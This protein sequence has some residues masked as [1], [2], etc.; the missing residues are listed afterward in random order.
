MSKE[1][2]E[3]SEAQASL[4]EAKEGVKNV[5]RAVADAARHNWVGVAV[6]VVKN[7]RSFLIG[8][9]ILLM[10]PFVLFVAIPAAL[11]GDSVEDPQL[12]WEEDY[13]EVV[14]KTTEGL[15]KGYNSYVKEAKRKGEAIKNGYGAGNTI[16]VV[17]RPDMSTYELSSKMANRMMATY[18]VIQYNKDS[19]VDDLELDSFDEYKKSYYTAVGKAAVKSGSRNNLFTIDHI[20]QNVYEVTETDEDGETHSYYRGTIVV[21]VKFRP[22]MFMRKELDQVIKD[23]GGIVDEFISFN[24]EDATPTQQ[25]IVQATADTAWPG[26]GLCATWAS[27]VYSNAG[28]GGYGGNANDMWANY[29]Y[30]DDRSELAPGMFIAVEH[31]G[32]DYESWTYGHVG[33]YIGNDQV[34]HS[35]SSGVVVNTVDEWIAIFDPYN[36]VRWGYP[37]AVREQIEEEAG[38]T[39]DYRVISDVEHEDADSISETIYQQV[40]DVTEFLDAEFAS[41][42]YQSFS[43]QGAAKLVEQ[44]KARIGKPRSDITYEFNAHSA[45]PADDAWDAEFVNACAWATGLN[46]NENPLYP[47]MPG[48]KEMYNEMDKSGRI[49]PP[50]TTT[51]KPGY[52]MFYTGGSKMSV[53][54]VERYEEEEGKVYVIVGADP[55][56]KTISF[57]K[58]SGK[59]KGYGVPNFP[60]VSTTAGVSGA[61]DTLAEVAMNEYQRANAAGEVGGW[62]YRNWDKATQDWLESSGYTPNWC[63]CFVSWCGE[64]LGYCTAGYF[65]RT[66][67]VY[68]YTQWFYERGDLGEVHNRDGYVPVAGDLVIYDWNGAGTQDHIEIVTGCDGGTFTSIG[69]NSGNAFVPNG[70]RWCDYS[71]VASHQYG[72]ND[73]VVWGY[74]HPYYDRFN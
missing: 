35:V 1:F 15:I 5:G 11:F 66:W 69:G 13:V 45:Y 36:S 62:L 55:V 50:A 46:S 12:A 74:V 37:Q 49:L 19:D 63:A 32:S 57:S 68:M 61:G 6:N 72:I 59:I 31:S 34:M 30:S 26:S 43:L 67:S 56:V 42:M 29:C 21:N 60:E 44:A 53:G 10:I 54:I 71:L 39:T 22:E 25:R 3:G 40:D 52:L 38:M 47:N 27:W 9:A 2:S 17:V 41:I 16:N 23:K 58:R 65:P 18:H 24:L 4:D 8:L 73:Y 70:G 64:Q 48:T 33:V 14:K 7:R 28:I 20:D 51:P